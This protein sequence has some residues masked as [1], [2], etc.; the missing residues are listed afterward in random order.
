MDT[1]L[2]SIDM[3]AKVYQS[4]LVQTIKFIQ[5]KLADSDIA[6][7]VS[8]SRDTVLHYSWCFTKILHLDTHY[9]P[10]CGFDVA[11]NL[12]RHKREEETSQVRSSL[13]DGS[14]MKGMLGNLDQIH[15]DR[16]SIDT[17]KCWNGT[18]VGPYTGAS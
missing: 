9:S 3:F 14:F 15:C 1:V 10:Q 7:M 12:A 6:D 2:D 17:D 8:N 11:S 16:M 13:F 4:G 18:S 5:Q